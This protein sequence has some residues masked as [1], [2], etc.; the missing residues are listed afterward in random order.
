MMVNSF[1]RIAPPRPRRCR[2]R[3]QARTERGALFV[4]GSANMFW[5]VPVAQVKD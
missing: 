2:G 4:L 3:G 1:L 5:G